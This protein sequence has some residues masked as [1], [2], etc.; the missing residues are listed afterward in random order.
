MK[1]DDYVGPI[2]AIIVFITIGFGHII[3]RSLN[4]HFGTKPGIPLLIIGCGIM[5]WSVFIMSD[6]LSA[7]M[8]II[9]ITILW[10]GIEI[11]RQEKRIIKGHAPENPNRPVKNMKD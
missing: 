10:D 2:L 7:I 5:I 1:I 9:G 8:G 11:Y 3:V 6:L 4:F